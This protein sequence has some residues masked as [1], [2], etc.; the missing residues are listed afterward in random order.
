MCHFFQNS[1]VWDINEYE[2]IPTHTILS[3]NIAPITK[4]VAK[5][6]EE[7]IIIVLQCDCQ[8]SKTDSSA[9]I[10]EKHIIEVSK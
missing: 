10:T 7:K 5:K 9:R 4:T 1:C 8:N 6:G 2:H 3:K